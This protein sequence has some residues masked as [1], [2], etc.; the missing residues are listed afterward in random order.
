MG[1]REIVRH[2]HISPST[3]HLNRVSSSSVRTSPSAEVPRQR[4]HEHQWGD[5]EHARA[6][7]SITARRSSH[8][9]WWPGWLWNFGSASGSK[10]VRPKWMRKNSR[11]WMVAV[12]VISRAAFKQTWRDSGKVAQECGWYRVSEISKFLKLGGVL[13]SI[14]ALRG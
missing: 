5:K 2:W 7:L 10:R 3:S 13:A 4:S 9:A 14:E 12:A 8:S 11:A 6:A 1:G